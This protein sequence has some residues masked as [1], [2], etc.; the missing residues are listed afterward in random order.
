[1]TEEFY[2]GRDVFASIG[3][4]ETVTFRHRD[5]VEGVSVDCAGFDIVF[6]T[7]TVRRKNE[8]EAAWL[9]HPALEM[10]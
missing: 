4:D 5:S 7:I 10:S 9:S 2:I 1:M 3:E 8:T 6:Q